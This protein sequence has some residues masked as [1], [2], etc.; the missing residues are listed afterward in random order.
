MPEGEV[1][2]MLERA[3]FDRLLTSHGII[4]SDEGD[5]S[6]LEYLL[7]ALNLDTFNLSEKVELMRDTIP[8]LWSLG[9]QDVEDIV[10]GF[11]SNQN[12]EGQSYVKANNS[13]ARNKSTATLS[14]DEG[15]SSTQ[16]T[17][18]LS[19]KIVNDIKLILVG[20]QLEGSDVVEEE[21]VEYLVTFV[22]EL[23]IENELLTNQ[24]Q[25]E[26]QDMLMSFFPEIDEG[27]DA[28]TCIAGILLKASSERKRINSKTPVPVIE[29]AS[30][31]SS[32]SSGTVSKMGVPI[33]ERYE[34]N[35]VQMLDDLSSL[36][37]MLPH[38][39]KDLIRY[40]Y[41]TICSSNR[42]EAAQY[43][44]ERSDEEGVEK[45]RQSLNAYQK[46]E[47]ES[48]TMSAIQQKK[49]KA[50]LCTKYGDLLVRETVDAKGKELKTKVL[51]PIQFLDIKE[52]DKKVSL[53]E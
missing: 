15:S 44:L 6:V 39:S 14:A 18:D 31:S 49:M 45:L 24:G 37:S 34:S 4:R 8:S 1:M 17:N 2:L 19:Q 47:K 27:S 41:S 12:Q 20:R 38:I 26:L 3:K 22:N 5:D 48:A 29:A 28:L 35:S 23:E 7:Q 52:K 32:S 36:T 33:D 42:L 53:L 9:L 51:L 46:K 13:S 25:D 50:S 43:L 30:I 16:G 21:L 40:V 11:S 10:N